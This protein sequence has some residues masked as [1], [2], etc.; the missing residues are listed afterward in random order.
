VKHVQKGKSESNNN[1]R[2]RESKQLLDA[3]WEKRIQNS[4][5][6]R[7]REN[8]GLKRTGGHSMEMRDEMGVGTTLKDRDHALLLNPLHET[9]TAS[10]KVPRED[11]GALRRRGVSKREGS[12]EGKCQGRRNKGREKSGPGSR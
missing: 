7:G 6:N 11:E 3:K 10:A 2:G 12:Q 5:P 1:V 8:T 9:D 4:G